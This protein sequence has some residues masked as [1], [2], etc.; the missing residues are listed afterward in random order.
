[1]RNKFMALQKSNKIK[2]DLPNPRI[3]T[4]AILV[5]MFQHRLSVEDDPFHR[6]KPFVKMLL[7]RRFP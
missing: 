4:S 5:S 2:N 7:I 1:M 3:L 6:D